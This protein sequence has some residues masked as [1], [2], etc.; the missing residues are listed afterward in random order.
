MAGEMVQ[1][2]KAHLT[3]SKKLDTSLSTAAFIY[4]S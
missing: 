4:L 2:L 3:T 1:L